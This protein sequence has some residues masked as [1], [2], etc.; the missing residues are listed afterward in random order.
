MKLHLTSPCGSPDLRGREAKSRGPSPVGATGKMQAQHG[1]APVQPPG[2]HL[3]PTPPPPFCSFIQST[4]PSSQAITRTIPS[5]C[6]A[7][8]WA[9]IS[10]PQGRLHSPFRLVRSPHLHH[11]HDRVTISIIPYVRPPRLSTGPCWSSFPS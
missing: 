6:S 5:V 3:P 4:S 8:C 9:E 2:L 1:G 10:L 11:K 7:H